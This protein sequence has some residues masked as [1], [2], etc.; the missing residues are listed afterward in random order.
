MIFVATRHY[1]PIFS[2][3]QYARHTLALVFPQ[4]L[5]QHLHELEHRLGS[6]VTLPNNGSQKQKSHATE[7]PLK[8]QFFEITLI[9]ISFLTIFMVL[10]LRGVL[11]ILPVHGRQPTPMPLCIVAQFNP[12]CNNC[13]FIQRRFDRTNSTPTADN[14][15]APQPPPSILEHSSRSFIMCP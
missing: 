9:L 10:T 1:T 5:R 3:M 8:F 13:S 6:A 4:L 7:V 15:H 12:N 2:T 11:G 14:I